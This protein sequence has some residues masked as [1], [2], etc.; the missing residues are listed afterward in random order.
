MHFLF[1]YSIL[2]DIYSW[3]LWKIFVNRNN[4]CQITIFANRKNINMMTF[5]QIGI[6]IYSLPEYQ[7]SDLWKIY[8]QT[9]RKLFANR[10]LFAEHWIMS[11]Y[12]NGNLLNSVL[13]SFKYFVKISLINFWF[14]T[15]NLKLFLF[16]G[17]GSFC[18]NK[19]GQCWPN[20]KTES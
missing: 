8:L 4:I 19:R 20:S 10:E 5:W 16:F 14:V 12:K 7:W 1:I 15:P 6:G 9:I 3:I 2:K 17:Q 18:L 11:T 13:H